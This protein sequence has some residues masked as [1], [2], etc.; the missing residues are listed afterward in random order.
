M[1]QIELEIQNEELFDAKE[2]MEIAVEKYTELYDFAPTG[3]LTLSGEGRIIR[4]NLTA[5]IMLGKERN[6][7]I[8]NPFA[9]FIT[10]DTKQTLIHWL[11]EIFN[12]K[13]RQSCEVTLHKQGSELMYV[14][15]IGVVSGNGESCDISM[16]DVTDRKVALEKL[17]AA[18]KELEQ[19][20]SYNADKD[21]FIS[22][23]AHDLRNPFS[24]LLGYT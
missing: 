2:N 10:D 21:L 13:T 20:L 23:L 1:H 18:N 14:Y 19:S 15:L 4:M 22:V 11:K 3:Y 24:K 5:S 16:I 12:S 9:T 6:R 8:K 17:N 7:L